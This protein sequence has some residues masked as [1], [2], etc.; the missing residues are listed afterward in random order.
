METWKE[1]S[2]KL[3]VTLI[4]ICKS[5]S[6]NVPNTLSQ[7]LFVLFIRIKKL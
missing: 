3:K 1:L 4:P 2:V 5:C 6:K 7:K